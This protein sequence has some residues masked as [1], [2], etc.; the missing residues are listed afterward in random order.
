MA[1]PWCKELDE[2]DSI[3]DS[4]LEVVSC[5]RENRLGSVLL[6][7]GFVVFVQGGR[8]HQ[9]HL[10]DVSLEVFVGAL[11]SVL[12]N[13]KYT[14]HVNFKIIKFLINHLFY[15]LAV[16]NPQEGGIALDVELVANGTVLGAI[17]F[18]DAH[19][20]VVFQ[21]VGQLVPSGCQFLTMTTPWR[22]KLDEM[23]ARR[24]VPVKVL[25]GQFHQFI[26]WLGN[27]RGFLLLKVNRMFGVILLLYNRQ[28]VCGFYETYAWYAAKLFIDE[29]S[30]GWQVSRAFELYTLCFACLEEFQP[31][32][33]NESNNV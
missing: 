19:G 14:I 8:A 3:L 17:D 30:Q 6:G 1:A 5:Q 16:L 20:I 2:S 18:A 32:K 33:I 26:D 29:A 10:C 4:V 28:R 25:L 31:G 15:L 12:V 9:L 7:L 24:D 11:S 22:V 13:L 23:M 21:A 27:R